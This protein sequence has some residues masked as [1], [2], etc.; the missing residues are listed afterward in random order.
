[1]LAFRKGVPWGASSESM[2]SFIPYDVPSARLYPS[3]FVTQN[4]SMD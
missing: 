3:M 2:T 1:M 4:M